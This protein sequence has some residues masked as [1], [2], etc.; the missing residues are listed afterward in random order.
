MAATLRTQAARIGAAT[1]TA[2]ARITTH[3]AAGAGAAASAGA[4]IDSG[5]LAR[6]TA[7]ASAAAR[8]V[9]AYIVRR[10]ATARFRTAFRTT[11]DGTTVGT[12]AFLYDLSSYLNFLSPRGCDFDGT[13]LSIMVQLQPILYRRWQIPCTW[14]CFRLAVS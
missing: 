10:T 1:P 11:H 4:L 5:W 9:L 14:T 2:G 8:V 12:S 7:R 13:T 6:R 3:P